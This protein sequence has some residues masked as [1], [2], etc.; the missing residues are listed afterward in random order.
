M[1]FRRLSGASTRGKSLRVGASFS[2]PSVPDRHYF[3]EREL[4]ERVPFEVDYA[5]P[6]QDAAPVQLGVLLPV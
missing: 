6:V 4:S 2:R 5:S 1:A 3:H